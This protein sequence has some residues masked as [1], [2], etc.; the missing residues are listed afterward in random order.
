MLGILAA[1]ALV[2]G[3]V[4]TTVVLTAPHQGTKPVVTVHN[5]QSHDRTPTNRDAH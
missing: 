5:V 4:G 3:L 2:G 1:L